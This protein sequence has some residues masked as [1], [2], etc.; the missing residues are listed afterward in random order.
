MFLLGK[1]ASYRTDELIDKYTQVIREYTSQE[2]SPSVDWVAL[3]NLAALWTLHWVVARDL[4]PEDTPMQYI[5][6]YINWC[7]TFFSGT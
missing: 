5:Y 3:N 6:A 7:Q 2:D 4:K 1:C